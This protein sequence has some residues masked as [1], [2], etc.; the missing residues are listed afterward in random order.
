MPHKEEIFKICDF[1]SKVASLTGAVNTV[2]VTEDKK[3][4]GHNSD[5]EGFVN[6]LKNSYPDFNLKNKTD[7]VIG[8]GG[9][10]RAIVYSLIK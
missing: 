3:I 6:N 4:F 1:K 2:V 5:A 7:F 9:A 10:A 8:A